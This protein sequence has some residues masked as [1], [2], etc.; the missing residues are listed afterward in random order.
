MM[1][2]PFVLKKAV[3]THIFNPATLFIADSSNKATA[4]FT[5]TTNTDTSPFLLNSTEAHVMCRAKFTSY[6]ASKHDKASHAVLVDESEKEN[7]WLVA[8]VNEVRIVSN[9]IHMN[10]VWEGNYKPSYCKLQRNVEALVK[11]DGIIKDLMKPYMQGY[12]E[13]PQYPS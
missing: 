5:T 11:L 13:S 7:E 2:E 12:F 1:N 8:A 6:I 3:Q 4:R 9:Q 10:C